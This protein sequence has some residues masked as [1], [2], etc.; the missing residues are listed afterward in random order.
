MV[1][2]RDWL[3][4]LNMSRGRARNFWICFWPHF[5]WSSV[6]GEREREAQRPDW[7]LQFCMIYAMMLLSGSQQ[8]LWLHNDEHKSSALG[9]EFAQKI[10]VRLF[11]TT[12][13]VGW[14][15]QLLDLPMSLQW[16]PSPPPTS[17]SQMSFDYLCKPRQSG[18][19]LAFYPQNS[20]PH[21]THTRNLSLCASPEMRIHSKRPHSDA[22]LLHLKGFHGMF[23][24]TEWGENVFSKSTRC[25]LMES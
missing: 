25:R 12:T 20:S 6:G 14:K 17:F 1:I 10:L 24:Q 19:F 9:E 8:Q 16:D 4:S 5:R 2:E 13:L 21:T 22:S 7:K 23:M 15:F 11:G 18:L 3:L